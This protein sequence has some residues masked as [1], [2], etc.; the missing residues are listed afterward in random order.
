[1]LLAAVAEGKGSINVNKQS[2]Q[3]AS[4]C[5]SGMHKCMCISRFQCKK[6]RKEKER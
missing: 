4:I 5:I 1:M 3:K 6:I 2:E